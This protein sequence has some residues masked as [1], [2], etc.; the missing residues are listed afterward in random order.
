MLFEIAVCVIV[1]G[2]VWLFVCPNDHNTKTFP[3]PD[4][5][6]DCKKGSCEGCTIKRRDE[7][8]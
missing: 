1:V 5:C 6:W 3:Y 7:D 2:V 8:D 4:E